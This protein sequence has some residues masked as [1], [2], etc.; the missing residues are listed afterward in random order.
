MFPVVPEMCF[1]DFLPGF[2]IGDPLPVEHPV[3]ILPFFVQLTIIK[4]G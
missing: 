1:T 3:L 4:I 2:I